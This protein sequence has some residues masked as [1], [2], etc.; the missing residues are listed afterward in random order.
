MKKRYRYLVLLIIFL[1][2]VILPFVVIINNDTTTSKVETNFEGNFENGF[3]NLDEWYLVVYDSAGGSSNDAEPSLDKERGQPA[4]SLDVNG[5][6]W[7]GNGAYT[8][9]TFDYSKGITIEFDM[10]VASGYD[11]NWGRG[12]LSD[13]ITNLD[14]PRDDGAYIDKKRCGSSFLA[15][16]NFQDDG[17]Y[18]KEPPF[19][20]FGIKAND[21]S[22]VVFRYLTDSS[23]YQNEWHSY[24][25]EILNDGYVNFF[26]D[27]KF[28]WKSNK[29][30]NMSLGSLPLLFGDRDANGPVRIDNVKLNYNE[31]PIIE[32]VIV[33][34]AIAGTSLIAFIGTTG[35]GKYKFLSFLSLFGPLYI[36]TLK[37]DVFDNQKRLDMYN[38]IAENQPVVY[39]DIRKAC[40]LSHGEINWHARMMEQMDII[41][42][43]RRGVNLFFK[44]SGERLPPA[45]FIRLTDVQKNI[46]EII[47]EKPGVTQAEI[48]DK[49]HLKQQN[50]SYNLLKLEEKNQIKKIT[51]NRI[52][53]YY[54]AS[55]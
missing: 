6:S 46:I 2:L 45:K 50:I 16:I 15:Y 37:D 41:K 3:D 39:S 27:E 54:S 18:G 23:K 32:I 35:L 48:A 34:T 26:M 43:E 11:W 5:N 1:I 47:K 13:H 53:Y 52:K 55:E 14:S 10:Y 20:D 38:H 28:I 40:N 44:V 8:K 9:K 49:L 33:T 7:C 25:I 24:K 17:K 51:K 22:V 42:V 29:S 19:L 30:I 31:L 12:G 21:D 4:P 36:R